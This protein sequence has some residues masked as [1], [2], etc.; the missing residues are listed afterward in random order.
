MQQ[1]AQESL[2]KKRKWNREK[3]LRKWE[4][5]IG[6]IIKEKQSFKQHLSTHKHTYTIQ[7]EVGYKEK[8][9]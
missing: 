7:D 8:K 9:L 2:G 5:D 6:K 4:D 3:C 1:A